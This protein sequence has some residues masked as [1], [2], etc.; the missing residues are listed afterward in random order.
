MSHKIKETMNYEEDYYDPSD[1]DDGFDAEEETYYALGGTEDY[2][3]W[4]E[5]GGDIDEMM[6]SMGF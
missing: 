5:R 4:K 1:Y 3:E 6:D 2:H